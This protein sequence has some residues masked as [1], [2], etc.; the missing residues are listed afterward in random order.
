[1]N[2]DIKLADIASSGAL[3]AGVLQRVKTGYLLGFCAICSAT[4]VTVSSSAELLSYIEGSGTDEYDL[5]RQ[6]RNSEGD[7]QGTFTCQCC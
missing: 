3:E 5:I 1:M 7:E 2:L 6:M 4:L